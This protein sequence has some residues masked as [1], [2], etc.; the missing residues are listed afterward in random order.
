LNNV[1]ILALRIWMAKTRSEARENAEKML[2]H[3]LIAYDAERWMPVF[4]P[5]LFTQTQDFTEEE[6]VE[7]EFGQVGIPNLDGVTV[8]WTTPTTAD[9][10]EEIFRALLGDTTGTLTAKDTLNGHRP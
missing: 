9:E 3:S 5:E 1:Q 4:Y 2:Q 8:K 6:L 10:A 7:D